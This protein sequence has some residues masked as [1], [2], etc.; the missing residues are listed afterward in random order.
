MKIQ[1]TLLFLM[2]SFAV[3]AQPKNYLLC[4]TYTHTESKGIYVYDFDTNTG[5]A[6]L[7]STTFAKNPSYITPSADGKYVY[8]VLENADTVGKYIG[9]GIASYAF[10]ANSGN[11]K[12]LNSKISGGKHPCF[13]STDSKGKMIVVANYSSGSMLAYTLFSNGTIDSLCFNDT[14]VGKGPVLERQHNAHMH[15]AVFSPD[16]KYVLA[17]DL[18]SDRLY[19]YKTNK[20]KNHLNFVSEY[21]ANP[22]SGPRH[23]DFHPHK[24]IV[25]L[26]EELTATIT[27]LSFSYGQLMNIQRVEM[28]PNIE[29]S[30]K[31][32]ADI[33]VSPDGNFV[34]ASIRGQSNIIA[35]YAIHKKHGTLSFVAQQSTLGIKPRNFNFDPTGNFL[36]VANQESNEIVIFKIDHSTG[37][38]TDTGNRIKVPKPVCLKWISK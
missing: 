9:G 37:L 5:T 35:I 16:G 38:L 4:G 29:V 28:L 34:Y 33:H 2:V 20:E 1:L 12:S 7:V 23:L 13:I 24:K 21:R 15:A 8:A 22:G 6:N 30:D 3:F 18:G 27:V 26:V 31:G 32:A 10:D 25:Y 11:L 17:P 36:L 19:V 14:F